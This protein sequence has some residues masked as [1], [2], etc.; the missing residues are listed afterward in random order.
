MISSATSFKQAKRLPARMTRQP[1]FANNFAAS[2]PIP[3]PAPV[4]IATF[5]VILL[6]GFLQSIFKL[7]AHA[8]ANKGIIDK[9]NQ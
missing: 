9:T 2:A 1:F 8:T 6:S 5:F 4:I 7:Y 3:D